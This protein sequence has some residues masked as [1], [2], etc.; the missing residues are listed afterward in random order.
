M[1]Y[2]S[3]FAYIYIMNINLIDFVTFWFT[4]CL[5]HISFT[6]YLAHSRVGRGNLV[7]RHSVLRLI[8]KNKF[9]YQTYLWKPDTG[10]LVSGRYSVKRAK[11]PPYSGM[12][13]GRGWGRST[14]GCGVSG[15][16]ATPADSHIPVYDFGLD[17]KIIIMLWNY[18]L[19]LYSKNKI[20]KL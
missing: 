4:R 6:L 8:V 17:Y 10:W 11:N 9:I 18:K 14:R 19:G 15:A 2:V 3:Y 16:L 20:L 7:L 5:N 12:G 13:S 1:L